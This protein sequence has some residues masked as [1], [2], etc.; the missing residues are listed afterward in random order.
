MVAGMVLQYAVVS[1]VVALSAWMVLR[2]QFPVATRRLRIALAIPL[3]RE[4]RPRWL[5]RVGRRLAPPAVAG[6]KGCGACGG[7]E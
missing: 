3:V 5:R 1:A 2:R 6:G 4:G 7:C